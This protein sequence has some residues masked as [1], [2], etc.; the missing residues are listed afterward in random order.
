MV[1]SVLFSFQAT[2]KPIAPAPATGEATPA[3]PR[4]L[5]RK[6]KRSPQARRQ[7]Q[8]DK[9]PKGAVLPPR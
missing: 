7:A 2:D 3:G 1:T 6:E 8:V 5:S 4:A 9:L